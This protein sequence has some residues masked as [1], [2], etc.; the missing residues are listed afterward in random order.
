LSLIQY[1]NPACR[2]LCQLL[3]IHARAEDGRGRCGGSTWLA[4]VARRPLIRTRLQAKNSGVSIDN[5][6]SVMP[7][8]SSTMLEVAQLR[9]SQIRSLFNKTTES[10]TL[11]HVPVYVTW[12]SVVRNVRE[13]SEAELSLNV[14][15]RIEILPDNKHIKQIK[16]KFGIWIV[17]WRDSMVNSARKFQTR[18]RTACKS[19]K[20]P[21]RLGGLQ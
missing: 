21:L 7:C 4:A 2:A 5:L 1:S 15:C 19:C 9:S 8:R 14:V 12:P 3:G 18:R 13:M 20:V 17:V 10:R 6:T 16:M 11:C